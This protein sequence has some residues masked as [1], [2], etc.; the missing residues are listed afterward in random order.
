MLSCNLFGH[1]METTRPVICNPDPHPLYIT[2]TFIRVV[3]KTCKRCGHV[4]RASDY[5]YW[6]ERNFEDTESYRFHED[7]E[8]MDE[9]YR[10]RFR[11]RHGC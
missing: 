8:G 3:E 11:Y 2:G 9:Y 4:E 5:D 6:A 7:S 10:T 1:K